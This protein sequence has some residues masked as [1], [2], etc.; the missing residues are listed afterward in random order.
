MKKYKNIKITILLLIIMQ[1]FIVSAKPVSATD[2]NWPVVGGIGI[3]PALN[4]YGVTLFDV[5]GM[6]PSKEGIINKDGI[7][8]NFISQINIDHLLKNTKVEDIVK[9]ND[10][11]GD[12]EDDLQDKAGDK[13]K[14]LFNEI[15]LKVTATS[16]DDTILDCKSHD[17][18]IDECIGLAPGIV[19]VTV[20]VPAPLVIPF[21]GSVYARLLPPSLGIPS[22]GAAMYKFGPKT[23]TFPF[24]VEGE[25][26]TVAI[27]SDPASVLQNQATNLTWNSTNASGCWGWRDSSVAGEEGLAG[28][29]AGFATLQRTSADPLSSGPLANIDTYNFNISCWTPAGLECTATT[30]VNVTSTS[31]MNING[32]EVG[33]VGINYTFDFTGTDGDGDNNKHFRYEIDWDKDDITDKYLPDETGWVFE[34]IPQSASHSW[35]T[36]GTFTFQAKAY[37]IVDDVYSDWATHT[38][39]IS[40][41]PPKGKC[42]SDLTTDNYDG[43]ETEWNKTKP[44]EIGTSDPSAPKYPV[45]GNLTNWKC[46]SDGGSVPCQACKALECTPARQEQLCKGQSIPDGCGGD[47]CNGLLECADDA[48]C[49]NGGW[50]EVAPQ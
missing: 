42:N 15:N 45:P 10:F 4:I 46:M 36:A 5:L 39:T 37:D 31:I 32:T 18:N 20:H 1:V 23:F 8:G 44:C 6:T 29:S 40:D 12:M 24:E 14:G 30:T 41:P 48:R 38:I 16:S 21:A 25:A 47:D 13:L 3:L 50:I 26:C 9:D 11:E 2:W 17:Y 28:G 35:S 49:C 43:S 7:I 19:E 22:I 27:S 34:E 33:D